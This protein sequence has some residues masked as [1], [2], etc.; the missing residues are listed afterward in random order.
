MPI[1]VLTSL[2]GFINCSNRHCQTHIQN[3]NR[4]MASVEEFNIPFNLFPTD[5][6]GL[7]KPDFEVSEN[8]IKIV[9][10][11]FEKDANLTEDEKVIYKLLSK[12][13]LKPM[14][15]IAP[16]VP[17]GKSKTRCSAIVS[18]TIPRFDARCPP[19][20]LTFLNRKRR[21]SFARSL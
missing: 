18:S 16:Y 2:Y 4:M 19:V 9:L 21:I 15:E 14:S 8:A 17:F 11:L 6:E 5:S 10:P 1:Q 12:T 3:I 20:R 7:I 13:M